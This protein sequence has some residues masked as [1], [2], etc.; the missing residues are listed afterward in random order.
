M[1]KKPKSDRR[2]YYLAFIA[3]ILC[4]SLA[5]SALVY[6]F[7]AADAQSFDT[8]GFDMDVG[9]GTGQLP[10]NWEDT[11]NEDPKEDYESDDVSS[12]IGE[13][14]DFNLDYSEMDPVTEIDS[15]G[16]SQVENN[17]Q[18]SSMGWQ[19]G[20][21]DHSGGEEILA[22]KENHGERFSGQSDNTNAADNGTVS[23]GTAT[24]EPVQSPAERPSPEPSPGL[25]ATPWP[26][27]T[28]KVREPSEEV[29]VRGLSYYRKRGKES[30]CEKTEIRKETEPVFQG[31]I[32]N[33][34]IWIEIK[35]DVPFQ[36]LSFRLRGKECDFYWQEKKLLAKVPKGNGKIRK[37]EILGFAKSGRLYHE[38]VDLTEKQ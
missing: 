23:T 7:D 20:V 6:G 32:H 3:V 14:D 17:Q 29:S 11:R 12:G 4:S 16:A 33:D 27:K 26:T 22:E 37:A 9:E 1:R 28:V 21:G 24:P 30:F 8:G 34:Q 35:E 25:T 38:I 15:L 19:N 18:D 2:K 13:Q 5:G 31:E 36:I 10:E